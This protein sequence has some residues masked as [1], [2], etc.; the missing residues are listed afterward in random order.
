MA[1]WQ[2]GI[3]VRQEATNLVIVRVTAAT[4]KD[5][6]TKALKVAQES[7]EDLNNIVHDGVHEWEWGELEVAGVEPGEFPVT[8]YDAD[9]AEGEKP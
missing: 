7:R 6:R 1:T 9:I 8:F 5:A 2:I 3:Q 4:E